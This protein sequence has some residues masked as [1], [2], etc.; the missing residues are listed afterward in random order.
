MRL[1]ETL[2]KYLL[3]RRD[4]RVSWPVIRD[5][6]PLARERGWKYEEILPATI[7]TCPSAKGLGEDFLRWVEEGPRLL[8][9]HRDA[10]R[11]PLYSRHWAKSLHSTTRYRMDKVFRCAVPGAAVAQR[12]GGVI[13]DRREWLKE[14]YLLS[15]PPRQSELSALDSKPVEGRFISLVTMWGEKNL[16][17]YFF[18]AMLRVT[19]CEDV[20][21]YRFL[22]PARRQAWHDG[23]YAVA[24]IK[25]H[26]LVPM[27]APWMHVEEMN[28]CHTSN[29][30]SK[31]RAELLLKFR[32]L[33]LR[34]TGSLT[35]ARRDRRIFVDRSGAKRRKMA[36][37]EELE[38]VLAERGFEIIRWEEHSMA[39][40]IRIAAEANVMVGPHGTTL[41]N[42][43]YCQPG[44][45]LLE[46]FNPEWWDTTTLRQCSLAGHEFWYCFGENVSSTQDTYITPKKLARV[47]D[48]MLETGGW[49][50]SPEELSQ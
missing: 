27:E 50:E 17:H 43:L 31:P 15:P 29:S 33:A 42:S 9:V 2:K 23:L 16:G 47:L 10:R 6:E 35:P 12:G 46:I 37:Q 24:G 49:D 18:D 40:Q 7:Q 14:G 28:V 48:Y 19:L 45:K 32:D 20:A 11:G 21:N 34:N 22:V 39:E 3:D 41:L 5:L 1:T 38:P 30:G 25:E 26:Q 36:R 44:A 4:P 13:S 8:Q